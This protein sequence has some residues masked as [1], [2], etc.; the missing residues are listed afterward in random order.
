MNAESAE[1][2]VI[3]DEAGVKDSDEIDGSRK[4]KREIGR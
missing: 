3:L 4:G 1:I 2:G